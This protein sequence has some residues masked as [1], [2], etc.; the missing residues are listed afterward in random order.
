MRSD[1]TGS[2]ITIEALHQGNPCWVF[3]S[4]Q[5]GAT[6]ICKH[7]SNRQPRNKQQGI[8]LHQKPPLINSESKSGWML[9]STPVQ[10]TFSMLYL[11]LV[12]LS[13]GWCLGLLDFGF[14]SFSLLLTGSFRFFSR[15]VEDVD[16]TWPSVQGQIHPRPSVTGQWLTRL[17]VIPDLHLPHS[18]AAHQQL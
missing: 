17:N 12:I 5:V 15:A 8:W 3:G 16:I 9:R 4:F 1:K 18:K 13:T 10:R 11:I 7:D 14:S 6:L 2:F